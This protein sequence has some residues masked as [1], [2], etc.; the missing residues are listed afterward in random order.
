MKCGNSKWNMLSEHSSGEDGYWV[1][2]VNLQASKYSTEKPTQENGLLCLTIKLVI[3]LV[4][5]KTSRA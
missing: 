5:G 4:G 1:M 2:K 3:I